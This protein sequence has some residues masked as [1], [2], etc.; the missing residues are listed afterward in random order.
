M[1]AAVATA[2]GA[3]DEL[4]HQILALGHQPRQAPC[5]CQLTRLVDGYPMSG[6]S[7]RVRAV[8]EI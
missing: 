4:A 5:A 1:Y 6:C 8:L 7:M 3:F 2:C